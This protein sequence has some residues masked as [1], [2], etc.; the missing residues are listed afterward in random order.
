MI[1][2]VSITNDSGQKCPEFFDLRQIQEIKD[3]ILGKEYELSVVF[4]DSKKIQELN[5]QYREKDSPTD[6]LSF[7]LNE[8]EGEIFFC[9]EEVIKESKKFERKIDNFLSFLFIHGCVHL[10]G[11]DHGS[12]MEETETEIR[13]KFQV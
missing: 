7:T 5:R 11:Y 13:K 10:K 12:K 9:M 8:N 2:K 3:H 1:Q 6:I 4:T